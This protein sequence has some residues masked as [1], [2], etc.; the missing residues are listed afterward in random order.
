MYNFVKYKMV[1]STCFDTSERKVQFYYGNL[2]V[3]EYNVGDCL[4]WGDP[5]EGDRAQRH[6]VV[7]GVSTCPKCRQ[8][9]SFEI[10]VKDGRIES[11]NLSSGRYLF[12]GDDEYFIVLSSELPG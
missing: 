1:C 8:T 2:R 11:V 6:V 5:Q 12:V 4:I 9:S 3:W 10:V 7:S